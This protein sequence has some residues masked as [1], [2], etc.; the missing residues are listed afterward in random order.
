[1][2]ESELLMSLYS[3]KFN[4][5]QMPI[6]IDV[7]FDHPDLGGLMFLSP[8]FFVALIAGVIMAFGF[9]F[10]LTNF[11]IAA[12]ISNW[13]EALPDDDDDESESLGTKV[14]KIEGLV[15]GWIL[16]TVNLA[17][18]LACF[19]AVKLTSIASV[20]G[21]AIIGVVIWSAYFL[22]LVWL[23]SSAVGSMIGSLIKTAFSGIQG[24]MG[25]AGSA[26]GGKMASDQ[27]VNT[28]EASV[29]A[30]RRE[31]GSAVDPDSIRETIQDYVGSLQLPKLD[32]KEIRG[33]FEKLLGDTDIKSLA[34]SDVLK[35]V[36]RQTF[37][38]LIS[39]RS[40]FSK[41]EINQV[42]D[43]LEG[44]WKQTFG[45]QQD[46]KDPNLELVD[47]LKF[48]APDLLK[49]DELNAKLSQ[50]LESRENKSE[51]SS[52][53]KRAM[54][55][56]VE[57]L[58]G[59]VLSRTDLSDLDVEKISGQL[60]QLTEKGKEQAKSLASK[61]GDKVPALPFNT[62]KADVENYLLNAQ[63]WHLNRETIKQEFRDVIYDAEAS[64][65][66]VLGQLEMLNP[67]YFAGIL[68]RREG[69]SPEQAAE[70]SEQLE[71]VRQ[72]VLEIVQGAAGEEQ[73]QD[74]RSRIENYLRSTGKEELNPEGIEKDFQ[75]LLEDRDAGFEALRDRLSHF[76]R[77]TLV[78]LLG[79]REDFSPEEADQLI[80]RLESSRDRVISKAQELQEQ[81]KSKA[82]E[83]RQKVEEYLR[84]T[85][86]EELNPEAIEREFQT[87]LS[88][89][90]AGL[91]ALRERL[92]Q[93][94]R[95]T[96]VQLLS[97]R[98]DLSEEQVN[99]AIDK[100]E[101]VRDNIIHAPQ[102]V[103]DKAKQQYEEVTT[104]IGEYLRHTNLEE[105]DPEGINRDLTKLFENPKEGALAL[106]ERLSQVDRETLVKLLSQRED[107][108]EEQ[109][110]RTI[111][112]VQDSI[113]SIV[114]S[115]R[116]LASRAQKTVKDF[117]GSLENYLR[118]TDKEELNPDGIKRDLQLLFNEP[119]AGMQSLGDRLKHFD[120]GTLVA[121]LSQR[122][123]ISEEEAN[124]IADRIESVRN[125]FVEQIQMVQDKFQS[126]I[127]GIFSKI[128]DYLN[129]LD[130]P[131]LNYEGIKRDFRKVFDDPQ[132]GFDAIKQRLGEFDRGTLVAL[133][134][135][136]S[137][138]SETD[139]H[140]IVDQM[141]G[142]RDSVILR[143]ERLQ[144]EAKKR[145]KEIKNKTK[146]QAEDAREAA[147]TAA[148]WLFGTALTS[149]VVSALAGAIA[150]G[151]IS[152]LFS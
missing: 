143:A 19:L 54:L 104:K 4:I 121:L 145:I 83:V 45:K 18:F 120:R 67:E 1:M 59:T 27:M 96:L 101:S 69:F 97:Q 72:E 17:L 141:E 138:I 108:S 53:M 149:V 139:A 46:K 2:F 63:P 150:V 33:Q 62:A 7:P 106:R 136:R 20:D 140:R 56:G 40:D 116:R 92:S 105:L 65:G 34:G 152:G 151:G 12:K 31:L 23:G 80:G 142:A 118:N 74:L 147:A 148:W 115:P 21:A 35:N 70:I 11:S 123:D 90:Q 128:R 119:G 55:L 68:R 81:A 127:D 75:A 42:A 51:S 64:P 50:I 129:S 126:T 28:V 14:R 8:Q 48:A 6:E 102:I 58:V 30:V 78:Q 32:V 36:N 26:I 114:K 9:Q 82:Q 3:P 100:I 52:G 84:N 89:P 144:T 91:K 135:S 137:D 79:Q 61:V 122:E 131:E 13:D 22:T 39:S 113:R 24:V 124:Q 44:V 73:S 93:F 41:E 43:Q 85:N 134:S 71:S 109:I 95:D 132:A 29:A 103:A 16:V 133:L 86:K 57:A 146:Q 130:R 10:L 112:R 117:Q 47:F 99:G 60:Q 110:N 37:V 76:D 66:A 111:D 49:S 25:T 87:L 88:D 107:L 15:G 5:A 94:D 125:E 98:Q 77:D 38:D